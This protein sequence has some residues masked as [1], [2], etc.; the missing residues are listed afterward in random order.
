[1]SEA[2]RT[3]PGRPEPDLP[4]WSGRELAAILGVHVLL[5]LIMTW[6]A[7]LVAHHDWLGIPRGDKFQ[8]V[9]IFWW[10]KYALLELGQLPGFTHLQYHPTGVSLALHDMT[11]FWSLLSV[12]LQVVLDPRVVLNL[13]LLICFPLNGLCCY[14]LA[15]E[16]TGSRAAALAASV[17]FAYCPYLMGRFRVSHIQYLGVFFI[18]LFARCLWRY[19]RDGE[20]RHLRVAGVWLALQSLVS[21]YYGLGL[22]LVLAAFVADR[23]RVGRPMPRTVAI[24]TA[25]LALIAGAILAPVALP[26]LRAATAAE[27]TRT[28]HENLGE[29]SAD[30]VAFAV[31][32]HTMAPW[33]GWWLTDGTRALRARIDAGTHGSRYERSVYPGWCSWAALGIVLATPTLRRRHWPWALLMGGFALVA[34][35]PDLYVAGRELPGL[36]P[37]SLLAWL[38]GFDM[39]RSATRF[40]AFT[41]LGAAIL[42]AVAIVHL[43]ARRPGRK[44]AIVAAVWGTIACAEFA[45]LPVAHF[46]F[47]TWLSPY[48]GTIARDTRDVAV[49]NVPVDF[50]DPRGGADLYEYAQLVHRKPIVGGY[51]SREPEAVFETLDASPFLQA[52]ETRDYAEAPHLLL[53]DAGR[54]DANETL[55]RLRIGYVVVHRQLLAPDDWPRV[56]AWL[57]DLLGAPAFEGRWIAAYR[58]TME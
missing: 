40:S 36:M 44:T 47:D 50:R 29:N 58:T 48:Y 21:F 22:S 30:L 51:V 56:N 12:P 16:V 26:M 32:D 4:P 28:E 43:G 15:R 9:W 31:P 38:P 53:D 17:V 23:L 19:A 13:F 7:L 41:M 1:M 27:S 25:S 45:A 46:P 6:P 5:T 20:G 10:V 8:F 49:L 11:Y 39:L 55:E 42:T 35:G 33:R 34:L 2:P 14:L 3:P 52:L 37:A 54:A 24:H 57:G 18:P